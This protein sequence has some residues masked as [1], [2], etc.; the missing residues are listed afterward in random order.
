MIT[1][2][3]NQVFNIKTIWILWKGKLSYEKFDNSCDCLYFSNGNIFGQINLD[4]GLVAYYPFNG[5]TNDE[6]RL[7]SNYPNPFNPGTTIEFDLPR[8]S[9]VTL[10]S[11]TSWGK[12]WSHL[13]RRS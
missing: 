4:S 8:T 6:I 5:N 7:Y 3:L 10:K 1:E 9:E 13:F 2:D 12:K 11:I